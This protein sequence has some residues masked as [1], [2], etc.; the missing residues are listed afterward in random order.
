MCVAVDGSVPMPP[1][2]HAPWPLGHG[3]IHLAKWLAPM[4][5]NQGDWGSKLAQALCALRKE[6]IEKAENRMLSQWQ[7]V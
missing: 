3:D 7:V 5:C 1:N 4:T 2:D 6:E